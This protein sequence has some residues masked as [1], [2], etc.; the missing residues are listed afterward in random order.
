VSVRKH[1]DCVHRRLLEWLW[2]RSRAVTWRC[3]A[4]ATSLSDDPTM[5]YL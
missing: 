1:T 3:S 5:R 2:T 4:G